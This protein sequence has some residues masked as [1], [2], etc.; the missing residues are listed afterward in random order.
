MSDP[1][2]ECIKFVFTAVIRGIPRHVKSRWTLDARALVKSEVNLFSIPKLAATGPDRR[3]AD[4]RRVLAAK[5]AA[6]L[7]E[8]QQPWRSRLATVGHRGR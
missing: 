5:I 1:V 4:Q 8:R 6:C 7:G 3:C 2:R